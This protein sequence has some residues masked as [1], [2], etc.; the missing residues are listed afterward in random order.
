MQNRYV[1]RSFGD[2]I[3]VFDPQTQS[4][5]FVEGT[6]ASLVPVFMENPKIPVSPNH[7]VEVPRI[8][9]KKAKSDAELVRKAVRD[10]LVSAQGG[11]SS[12]KIASVSSGSEESPMRR[13]SAYAVKNWRII[14]VSIE[15]TYR[16]NLRCEW[17]YLGKCTKTCLQREQLQSTAD[18]L[19]KVGALFILFTGGETFCR[20]DIFDVMADFQ[21][22]GFILEAKSNG[23]LLSRCAIKKLADLNLF[24][25]QV[26]IYDI[27]RRYSP[28]VRRHY[29]FDCLM[30]NIRVAV[31]EGIPISLAV[32]VGKHNINSLDRY[33]EIL[34]G[35]G[36]KEVSYSPYI[37]P[38]RDGVLGNTRLRLSREEME[39]KFYP[40]LEKIDGFVEP[41]KYRR[42]CKGGP[43][44]FAGRDQIAIDP[45]GKV[46]PC[47]DL[48]VPLGNILQDGLERILQYRQQLLKPYILGKIKKCWKCPIV[49]CRVKVRKPYRPA[50]ASVAIGIRSCSS[51]HSKAGA[52]CKTPKNVPC[53]VG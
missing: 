23:L 26:S 51:K 17:C 35:L 53:R 19:L 21:A 6:L 27:E 36:V 50:K 25:L 49:R 16:C 40:F 33:H 41:Q 45:Q 20:K 43:V 10:F 11:S 31:T 8:G 22:R 7:L 3:F 24:N 44:C 46:F 52:G 32:L 14:N 13:L 1:K 30:D 34:Q 15:V 9:M 47:L 4:S 39:E 38:R 18:Q 5:L 48:R 28:L 2:A 37:T 29:R 42:R 12:R